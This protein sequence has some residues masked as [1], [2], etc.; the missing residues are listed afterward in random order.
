VDESGADSPIAAVSVDQSKVFFAFLPR[1]LNDL[2]EHI[3]PNDVG[4]MV[5]V[6]VD[7][8]VTVSEL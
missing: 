8:H 5:P 3:A 7:G 1:L 2:F 6:K 4:R